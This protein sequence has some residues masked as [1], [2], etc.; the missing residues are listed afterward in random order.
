MTKDK[1]FSKEYPVIMFLRLLSI[2]DIK[3]GIVSKNDCSV[4]I[5]KV[6]RELHINSNRMKYVISVLEKM[7]ILEVI[8]TNPKKIIRIN[9]KIIRHL[10]KGLVNKYD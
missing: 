8:N 1:Y 10:R 9:K 4:G 2:F 5:R 6:R 7:N 3:N